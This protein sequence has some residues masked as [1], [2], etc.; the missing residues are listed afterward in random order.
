[1]TSALHKITRGSFGEI[2]TQGRGA[3]SPL[4]GVK[5]VFP[6]PKALGAIFAVVVSSKVAKKAVDR[7]RLKRRI[8]GL[9][10]ELQPQLKTPSASII[11]TKPGAPKAST[12]ELREVLVQT[13]GQTGILIR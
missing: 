10:Q 6:Y 13:L 12:M 7:N 5:T 3:H 1:M 11:L 4:L 2:Y 9:L 8:K